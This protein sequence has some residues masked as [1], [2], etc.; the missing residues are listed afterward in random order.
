MKAY[1]I[2]DYPEYYII[3][4]GDVYTRNYKN[5]GRFKKLSAYK[6]GSKYNNNINNLQLMPAKEHVLLH[7]RLKTKRIAIIKCPSCG[8][9]FEKEARMLNFRTLVFCSR[10]CIGKY[11][12]NTKHNKEELRKKVEESKKTNIIEIIN[13]QSLVDSTMGSLH[14]PVKRKV[15]GSNPT[16]PATD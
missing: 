10:Q 8:K 7:G 16:R 3:R 6:D 14:P 4:T 15:V 5:T 9:I 1:K 13:K 12:Y 2:K 11:G